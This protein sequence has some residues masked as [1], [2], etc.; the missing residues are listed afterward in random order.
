MKLKSCIALGAFALATTLSACGGGGGSSSPTPP[1]PSAPAVNTPPNA[2]ISTTNVVTDERQEISLSAAGS[3]D[4]DGDSLTYSWSQIAGPDLGAGTQTGDTF[5]AQV[6]KLTADETYTIELTV[7]DGKTSTTQTIEIIG[8]KIVLTPLATEWGTEV[9]TMIL[10][11]NFSDIQFALES[12]IYEQGWQNG[13]YV[14]VMVPNVS[15]GTNDNFLD[16]ITY[17][18]GYRYGVTPLYQFTE[19]ISEKLASVSPISFVLEISLSGL[20]A[21]DLDLVLLSEEKDKLQVFRRKSYFNSQLDQDEIYVETGNLSIAKPCL[22]FASNLKFNDITTSG[23]YAATTILVGRSQGGLEAVLNDAN[24]LPSSNEDLDKRGRF[25]SKIVLNEDGNFCD[26]FLG[27]GSEEFGGVQA[28][29]FRF[30][31]EETQSIDV[32]RLNEAGTSLG[33][34]RSSPI[35][36]SPEHHYSLIDIEFFEV[37]T[38]ID[39][40]NIGA[41]LLSTG[42]YKGDHKVAIFEEDRIV[43]L[44]DL[45]DGAPSDLELINESLFKSGLNKNILIIGPDSPYAIYFR[46]EFEQTEVFGS[47]ASPE[48]VNVGFD[49]DLI[50]STNNGDRDWMHFAVGS[51]LNKQ[52]KFYD[53]L[54]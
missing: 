34:V 2:D 46:S 25:S 24:P 17:R 29:V 44:L 30:F 8:R 31:N 19:Y 4:A 43:E 13:F 10:P 48:Y 41:M 47:F 39:Y 1:S 5:T 27:G 49:N 7:S 16:L 22:A 26:G 38:E 53:E 18:D 40:A 50:K 9:N 37:P 21:S 42:S 3:S 45:P 23:S 52:V 6:P 15:S 12:R 33:F 14:D 36:I 20:S 32:Y 35:S 11:D 51:K 54:K 28:M